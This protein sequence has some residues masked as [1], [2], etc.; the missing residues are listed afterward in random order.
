VAA[1]PDVIVLVDASWDTAA[2]KLRYAET[3]RALKGLR[4]L[5]EHHVVELPFSD[6]TPGVRVVTGIRRLA[7]SLRTLAVTPAP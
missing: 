3:S 6:T 4:A 2:A 1:D 5:R 7:D